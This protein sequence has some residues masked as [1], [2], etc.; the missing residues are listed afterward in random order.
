MPFLIKKN[1]KMVM[2]LSNMKLNA[3]LT[4]LPHLQIVQIQ[5]RQLFEELPDQGLL[6]L[7]MKR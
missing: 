5:I 1:L 7:L 4:F 3:A 2:I 6:G